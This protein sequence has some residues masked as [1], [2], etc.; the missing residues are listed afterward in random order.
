MIESE[1]TPLYGIVETYTRTFS[2]SST[3]QAGRDRRRERGCHGQITMSTQAVENLAG[4]GQ[5]TGAQS[6][7]QGADY[8][9]TIDT[10]W[11]RLW[12][13]GREISQC[14]QAVDQRRASQEGQ[15]PRR[16]QEEATSARGC[17]RRI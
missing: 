15:T 7:R 3:P 5:L 1:Q 9:P 12:S 8:G 17:R 13:G 6:A 4:D 2:P 11:T 14:R 16:L 10:I